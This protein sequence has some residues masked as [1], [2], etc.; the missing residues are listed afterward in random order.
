MTKSETLTKKEIVNGLQSMAGLMKKTG[1]I[2]IG[3]S[4]IFRRVIAGAYQML[5]PEEPEIE[6]GGYN[7]WYVCP[8]CHVHLKHGTR[9][10]GSCGKE[11]I[12]K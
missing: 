6:G 5:T 7:W 1:E 4:D 11:I 3:D 8:E 9:F 12:W 2:R 10:C